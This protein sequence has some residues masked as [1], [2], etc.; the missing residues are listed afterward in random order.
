MFDSV[1]HLKFLNVTT[2][3]MNSA[4][5]ALIALTFKFF[6]LCQFKVFFM[7]RLKLPI[8]NYQLP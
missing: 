2:G 1:I 5:I 7:R 8:T 3:S 6:T 4:L